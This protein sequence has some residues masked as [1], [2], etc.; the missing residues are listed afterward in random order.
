MATEQTGASAIYTNGVLYEAKKY[1]E[2]TEQLRDDMLPMAN[3]IWVD[4]EFEDD[5][6]IS[7]STSG[8][9]LFKQL[10]VEFLHCPW[11]PEKAWNY[12]LTVADYVLTSDKTVEDGDSVGRT[13]EEQLTVHIDEPVHA[14]GKQSIQIFFDESEEE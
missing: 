1:H 12:I 13:E 5:D 2:E 3:L 4:M 9:E 10:N 14:D 8:M 7:L 11:H 6:T